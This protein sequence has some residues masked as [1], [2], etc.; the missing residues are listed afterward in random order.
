MKPA[1]PHDPYKAPRVDVASLEESAAIERPLGLLINACITAGI[2]M[3]AAFRAGIVLRSFREIFTGMGANVSTATDWALGS[4]WLWRILGICGLAL[5]VWVFRKPVV[6][7]RELRTLR[8]VVRA[9]T[10][11]VGLLFAFAIVAVYSAIFRLGE[12]I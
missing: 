1:P 9:F 10:L 12:A 4:A 7:A 11:L 8:Y 2:T 3:L 6:S 5:A